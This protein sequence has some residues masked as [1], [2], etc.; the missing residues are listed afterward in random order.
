MA[1]HRARLEVSREEL[2]DLRAR[3]A[4]TRLP[5]AWP[6]AGRDGPPDDGP[7][8]RRLVDHWATDFD[9]EA[10]QAEIK[11]LPS[12]T[13]D[14]EG[15]PVHFLL[16]PGETPDPLPLVVTHG[17]PSSFLEMPRLADRLANP[18]RYGRD[19]RQAFTV[20]VPSL[21]GFGLSPQRPELP[22]AT[23]THDLWHALMYDELGFARY[24]AHG[25]D[26]GAGVTSLL[27]QAHPASVVGAHLLAVADPPDVDPDTLTAEER[28]YQAS[29]RRWFAEDGGYEHEQIT[30]PLT[31]SR[32]LSDSTVGL[33]AWI[34][35]KYRE[36]SD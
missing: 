6:A 17:W 22:A 8:L 7:V 4:R 28:A 11:A 34:V 24:G 36:W 33:L 26:L 18:S 13:A 29:E 23:G 12:Y 20:V 32:G 9:W 25:G 15:T 5:Q 2:G 10:R 3:L 27:A 14:V 30:R 19:P 31:L 16:Y 35:E 21:P 1:Q